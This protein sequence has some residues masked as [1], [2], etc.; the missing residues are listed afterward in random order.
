[1]LDIVGRREELALLESFLS[2]PRPSALVIDGD[3]GIGKTTLWRHSTL[4]A[5]LLR[6]LILCAG[7]TESETQLP[8]TA[9]GDLLS[10]TAGEV[11]VRLPHPERS[12]LVIASLLAEL[13]AS[14]P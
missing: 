14:P 2:G 3:A 4:Q 11:L 10:Y 8:F 12:V 6:H 7:A 1:M 9:I 13:A 5:E